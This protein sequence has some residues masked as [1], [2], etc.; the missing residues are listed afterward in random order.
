MDD[1][2]I[3]KIFAI[4]YQV[5]IINLARELGLI[6]E[7]VTEQQAYKMYGKS[8]VQKWRHK[9]WIVGYPTGNSQRAKFYYRR[10]ELE[11]ASRM[12]DL[13]NII[14]PARIKQILEQI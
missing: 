6:D 7:H 13:Q 4:G 5:G 8:R 12:L 2:T 3:E 10:S 1:R 11:T 9:R 14:P